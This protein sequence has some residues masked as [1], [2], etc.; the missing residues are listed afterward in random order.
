MA[1]NIYVAQIGPVL[2]MCESRCSVKPSAQNGPTQ[3]LKIASSGP[4][5]ADETDSIGPKWAAQ[6]VFEGRKE[7]EPT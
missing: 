2:K 6:N 3:C 5:W 4:N 7:S 1:Y